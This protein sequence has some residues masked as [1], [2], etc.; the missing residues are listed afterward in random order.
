MKTILGM[1][2]EAEK[3]K[4]AIIDAKEKITYGEYCRRIVS[5]AEHLKNCG[6]KYDD[7]VL[8]VSK[9]S[10][11][12]LAIFHA[13]QYIGAIPV[14]L[15]KS[16]P[17]IKIK[18]MF[19]RTDSVAVITE[20][21]DDFKGFIS[22]EDIE[23]LD[24]IDVAFSPNI[25]PVSEILYTTGTTGKSKGV[26]LS[27]AADVAVAENII[28][29]VNK[30]KNDVELIPMPLNHSFAIRRYFSNMMLGS[31]VALCDGV[32]N[33]KN[34]FSLIEE[35]RCNSIAMNPAAFNIVYKFAKNK[36]REVGNQLKYV[37]FGSAHLPEDSKQKLLEMLPKSHLYNMYG[38]T[39]AGCSCVLD[40]SIYTN[41][42]NCIGNPTVNSYFSVVDENDSEFISDKDNMGRLICSGAMCMNEYFGDKETTDSIMKNDCIF[43]NDMGYIDK[44]GMVFVFG[45]CDDVITCGGN[46]IN[47]EEV[48]D[49]AKLSGLV[50]DCV[51]VPFED[52]KIGI[53]PKLFVV[54]KS[55]YSE[56]ELVKFLSDEL[57]YYMLPKKF[58]LTDTIE[59][60]FN[61][62]PLRRK[63]R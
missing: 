50:E 59:K 62:K 27:Q 54:P 32:V 22:Y 55:D 41:L 12:Y 61:G 17:S 20:K 39:E 57:E 18:E 7:R 3:N 63:Y 43:S 10:A 44:N 42:P 6:I 8:I 28:H 19:E 14:P 4:T 35:N 23:K 2:A 34:F 56:K 11:L 29:G 30:S 15:E 38:S 9:Q 25:N 46:K 48:E 26:V 47:P 24:I 16:T 33:L 1:I 36:F 45:R 40:F 31:T 53:V 13:I 49:R 52:E 58:E 5:V 51:C 60:S 37:Q 21:N